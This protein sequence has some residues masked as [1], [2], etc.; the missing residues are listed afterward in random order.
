MKKYISL[1]FVFLSILFFSQ[2]QTKRYNSMTKKYEYFNSK[3][4]MIGYEYYNNMTRQWE[5]YEM[6][7]QNNYNEP[8]KLDLTSTFNAA[9]T[10]QGRYDNNTAYVQKEVQKMIQ[11][12]YNFDIPDSQK[13]EIV[14]NFKD[15][16]L[17]SVN[18]QAINY[19]SLSQ[20][21]D[22]LNYL[23]NSL[24]KIIK[25]VVSAYEQNVETTTT[26]IS[27]NTKK[28]NF[29]DYYNTIFIVDRIAIWSAKYSKFLSDE[30]ISSNSYIILKENTI[31]FK[32]ADG[33]LSYRNLENKRY[34]SKREGY[35]YTSDWGPVFID[36]NLTYV[37]FA[38]GSN[39][40]GD[41]Y[42]YFITK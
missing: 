25:N 3:G 5:Y 2:T 8:A 1:I 31:E 35:E 18:S 27:N 37:A 34:N 23:S 19:S 6:N 42:T 14:K 36:K 39:F 16:P 7:S 11:S 33:T 12:V 41:N 20:A 4:Q 10:L 32:R 21:N 30:N 13:Q 24:N 17:K 38:V 9:S 28:I 22:V 29:E 40:S 15:V 26:Q